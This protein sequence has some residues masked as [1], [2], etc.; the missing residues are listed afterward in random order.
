MNQEHKI[1]AAAAG[2]EDDA[3]LRRAYVS[4][5]WRIIPILSCLWLLAWVDRANI[6]FA[7]LQMLTDLH[8]GEAVYGF[9]AG[10]FFLGYVAFGIPAI[11]LQRKLG[12]RR[13]IAAI[14]VGWGTTSVAMVFASNPIAFYLLR[15]LLG[16]FEAGFYPVV[17]LYFATWFTTRRR[18]R[19]FSIFHSAAICSTVVVG[20]SGGFILD[21]MSGWLSVA[22]WRWMFLVQAVPTIVLGGLVL[23]ILPDG[24]HSAAWLSPEQRRLIQ[25]DL[26]SERSPETA[27]PD[28]HSILANPMVW[29]LSTIYFCILAANSALSFYIPTILSEAGFGGYTAIGN[30][31]TGI[32]LLGA[33]GNIAFS[34]YASRHRETQIF[35][36]IA[37]F[38]SV[39]SLI[40]L[41]FVWHSSRVETFAA[42]VLAL[43]GTGAGISLFW[44]TPTRYLKVGSLTI[45]VPFIS[46]VANIAGFVT[47]SL[48][49]YVR[50]LA[51]TYA[52][53]FLT[54]ACAQALA[55]VLL[56]AVIPIVVRGTNVGIATSFRPKVV[57][58]AGSP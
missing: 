22:G 27:G 52:A 17:I 12:A 31:L 54:A 30:A 37:S 42:L 49:G 18:T 19:N 24:P 55:G 53:G 16:A 58:K 47:P 26:D 1:M 56:I 32:C 4:S 29:L 14:A 57:D 46:S 44:Q 28:E 8:F 45:A 34:T 9:G 5:E 3:R 23:Y 35:C 41:V 40:V 15:F 10:L 13:L 7:K 48:T 6:S 33:F 36:A 50:E 38:L 21:H 51:G 2:R 25:A 39:A 43:A 20:L 11:L